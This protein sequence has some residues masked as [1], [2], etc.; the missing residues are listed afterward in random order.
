MKSLAC[1]V[2][3]CLVFVPAALHAQT[4]VPYLSGRVVDQAGILSVPAR[5][6]IASMLKAHE[7]A[8]GN[9]IA[10]LTVPALGGES[11]EDYAV[12]VFEDW[13][14][15]QA[16][17]DNGVLVVVAPQDRK[18]RIEV[19]YGLE[20]M[21]TDAASS[22]V[23]RDLMTPR[24]RE[25]NYDVGV[26][27]GVTGILQILEGRQPRDPEADWAAP[28]GSGMN[29]P[30]AGLPMPVPHKIL[31]SL[32][33]F[34]I[35]GLF[36]FI[37]LVT[38]GGMGW[39]LYVFLIPFWSMFPLALF[40]GTTG[41]GIA[42]AHLIGYPI[43]KLLIGRTGWYRRARE[44]LRTKGRARIGGFT[45]GAGGGTGGFSSGGGFSGGGGRS[46]GGGASGSW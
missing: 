10:V 40:G 2:I 31:A 19:G 28:G 21:L 7:A 18:M 32:F 23:I 11:V 14:L 9:Q 20:G 30:A 29:L 33:V 39:F 34:A 36:T 37:G 16:G 42:G 25:G 41:L 5:E 26:E 44:D 24:F 4:E 8:S 1:A 17:K 3:A 27:A 22:R 35:I 46:G 12:R 43:A 15:G 45:L 6:R 13:K 38:P